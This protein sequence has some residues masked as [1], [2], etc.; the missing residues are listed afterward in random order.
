MGH[1]HSCASVCV[2]VCVCVCVCVCMGMVW[3]VHACYITVIACTFTYHVL[4]NN[5]LCR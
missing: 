1:M 2:R 3:L 5:N 4:T